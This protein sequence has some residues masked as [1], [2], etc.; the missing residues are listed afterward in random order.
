M[1]T[2]ICISSNINEDTIKRRGIDFLVFCRTDHLIRRDRPYTDDNLFK[3]Y[4]L[5]NCS[6]EFVYFN[7]KCINILP[8]CLVCINK[9]LRKSI[10]H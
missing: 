7:L 4:C 8:S 9:L 10:L 1:L 2:W 6:E 3:I 5:I